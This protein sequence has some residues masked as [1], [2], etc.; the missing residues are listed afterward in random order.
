MK[1]KKGLVLMLAIAMLASTLTSCG[2]TDVN[3]NTGGT[4]AGSK[5]ESRAMR[6]IM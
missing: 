6:S 5:S 3:S 1:G 4:I 2:K